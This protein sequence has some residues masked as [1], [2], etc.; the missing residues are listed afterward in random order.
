[1]PALLWRYGGY[2]ISAISIA[3][4]TGSGLERDGSSEGTPNLNWNL[5]SLCK[6]NLSILAWK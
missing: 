5:P 2:V 4:S 1:M 3:L 6:N